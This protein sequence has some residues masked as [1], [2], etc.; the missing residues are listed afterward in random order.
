MEKPKTSAY[1]FQSKNSPNSK[2]WG[3][4]LKPADREATRTILCDDYPMFVLCR[5]AYRYGLPVVPEWAPWFL[6]DLDQRK[7]ILL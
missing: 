4:T 2:S 5:I 7:V 3:E 1:I 6:R